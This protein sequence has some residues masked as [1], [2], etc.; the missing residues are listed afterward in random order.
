MYLPEVFREERL[1]VLHGL[2]RDYPLATLVTAGP[3]GL[4]A[5]P[6]PFF[7]AEAGD[8]GTLRAHLAK[9]NSQAADLRAGCEALVIFSGPQAYVTPSW[10]PSKAEH[11][12]VAP[13][14]N[15]ATVQVRGAPRII[16]DSQWLL[17]LLGDFTDIQ[18]QA[19]PHPWRVADAPEDYLAAA[20]R[21]LV[22]LEI[23][24]ESMIGKWKVSQ[25]RSATDRRGVARGLEEDARDAAMAALVAATL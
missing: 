15:Y 17:A 11:G 24:I 9:G 14:W 4:A 6:I 21:G 25:N 16:D 18:E 7:L 1:E 13:T 8:K 23:P 19:Q 22:G 5:N 12:K 10:Y 2:I 3:Q 20:L